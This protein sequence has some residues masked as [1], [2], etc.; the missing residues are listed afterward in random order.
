MD[1]A[2]L[3]R[4]QV[5]ASN[6]EEAKGLRTKTMKKSIILAAA[7]LALGMQAQPLIAEEAAAEYSYEELAVGAPTAFDGG[8][9]TEMWG[10]VVSDL[11][12]RTL[13]HG[14]DLVEWV[15]AEGLFRVDPSVVSGS[16]V[17]DNAEGDRTYTLSIYDDLYYNDGTKI[18]AYDYAFSML[19]EIAPQIEEIGGTTRNAEYIKGYNAYRTG[20][21]QALSGVR[22][23]DEHTI[24]ITIDHAY[25]PFFYEA[26]LLD[27]TPYPI[28]VIAPGCVVVDNGDGVQIVNED[29]EVKEP[30]FTA[31][32][33][34][35]TILG[36]NG[37]KTN[38]TVTSGPYKLTGFDGETATF[39]INGYYKGNSAGVKPSIEKLTFSTAYNDT[40]MDELSAK[41]FGLLNK[42]TAADT[43][44][45]GMKTVAGSDD[46]AMSN[47]PR[48]GMSFVSFCCEKA[49]VAEAAVRQAIAM[50]MDK[51]QLVSDYVGSYGLRVDGYYGMGQWM[52]QIVSGSHPFILEQPKEG[53]EKA[54]QKY[55]EDKKAWEALSLDNVAVY[56]FNT[57]AAANL[58]AANGWTLNR[59]GEE[60][61]PE[62][63]DVRCKEIGGELVALDLRLIYPEGNTIAESL[64]TSFAD[65]LKEAGIALTIEAKPMQDLLR[66]YYRQ[67]GERTMDMI[68]LATNF[69]IVFDPSLNFDPDMAD[70]LNSAANTTGLADQELYNLAVDMRSTEQ[71]DA[72][73]YMQKWVKFEERYAQVLPAIPV[74]SNVYFDFYTSTLQN[75]NVSANIT[76]G[77]AIVEAYLSDPSEE[78][79]TEA[80][81]E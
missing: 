7:C 78:A 76:W 25:L 80:A 81:T 9:F 55:E 79:E 42:V 53:D 67:N 77:Q 73:A 52:Y 65:N 41:N 21:A 56:D 30:I 18:T 36:A 4:T 28:S 37:Y 57:E 59:D 26:A 39:E 75:Y 15:S 32:L 38:P 50:C 54:K 34:N 40:M 5:T 45:E 10:N 11:D 44:T 46:Y 60:F 22:V 19:L 27:C 3:Y 12:V 63:D 13:I 62:K 16:V 14:Y 71:G 43:L 20:E 70:S 29:E 24:A 69:D 1:S 2:D 8:F 31:D 61:D 68:Y 72:L 48:S 66:E 17:T 58:L 35:T 74:Y 51:D 33:L 64:Q 49:T 47:Y 23:L 6:N